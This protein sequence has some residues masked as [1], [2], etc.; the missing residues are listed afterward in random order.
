MFI[1]ASA[2]GVEEED[3]VEEE[4]EEEVFGVNKEA[5]SAVVSSSS[6]NNDAVLG[7]GFLIELGIA[8]EVR[9]E[10]E[11]DKAG[12]AAEVEVGRDANEIDTLPFN[13]L[14]IDS[15]DKAI[16]PL[17]PPPPKDKLIGFGAPTLRGIAMR[18]LA[19]GGCASEAIPVAWIGPEPTENDVLAVSCAEDASVDVGDLGRFTPIKSGADMLTKLDARNEVSVT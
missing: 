17:T 7:A 13:G 3:R 19:S 10:V 5:D 15:A 9:V 6:S 11:E 1:K 8:R 18:F 2:A 12:A 4:E 16:G 14:F